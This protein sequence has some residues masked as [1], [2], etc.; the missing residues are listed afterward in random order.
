MEAKEQTCQRELCAWIGE[1]LVGGTKIVPL[2]RHSSWFIPPMPLDD[3][4]LDARICDAAW[5]AVGSILGH[6]DHQWL[7]GWP[8]GPKEPWGFVTEP[9]LPVDDANAAV[10]RA[11]LMMTGWNVNLAVLRKDQSSW[12]PGACT[13]IVAWFSSGAMRPLVKNAMA[14]MLR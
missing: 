12:N 13:P 10:E 1:H 11:R 4:W 3:N 6:M 14:W 5:W 7:F 9:Y 2:G 8:D